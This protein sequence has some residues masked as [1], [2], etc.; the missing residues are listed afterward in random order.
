[1]DWL[2]EPEK[3]PEPEKL[4]EEEPE[5]VLGSLARALSAGEQEAWGLSLRLREAL[6]HW[7]RLA[8]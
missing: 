2:T 3:E 8:L 1:M 6:P 5:R 7:L 4:P